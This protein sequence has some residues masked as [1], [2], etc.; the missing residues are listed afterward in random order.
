MRFLPSFIPIVLVIFFSF[1]SRAQVVNMALFEENVR[2]KVDDVIISG[3][4]A[5]P[6]TDMPYPVVVLVSGSWYDNRDAEYDGFKPFQILAEHLVELGIAVLR[7][8]DRGVGESTGDHTWQYTID[9]YAKDVVEAAAYLKRRSDIDSSKIGVLGHS[10]GGNIASL[11]ISQSEDISF[12]ISMAGYGTNVEDFTLKMRRY[13]EEQT[14]KTSGEIE[15]ALALDIRLIDVAKT[16]KG[17]KKLEKDLKTQVQF[18]YDTL[19][20]TKKEEFEDF[21]DYFSSTYWGIML[22][23]SQTPY[24]SNIIN[25]NPIPTFEKVECPTLLMFG[26]GDFQIPAGDHEK[27]ITDALDKAGNKDYKTEVIPNAN[28]YFSDASHWGWAF[29]PGVLVAITEWILPKVDLEK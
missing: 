17:A 13:I 23:C 19:N 20:E 25:Y 26:G 4:L 29:S 10:L 6:D 9:D 12:F 18:E 11:A 15:A 28:H 22:E 7:Y 24:Y 1:S 8:D 3:S 27:P 14:A 5:L 21:D 2:F 16:G